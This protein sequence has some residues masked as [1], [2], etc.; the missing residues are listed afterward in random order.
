M[1]LTWISLLRAS[2]ESATVCN[3]GLI[4][5]DHQA[6]WGVVR[7]EPLNRQRSS[8]LAGMAAGTSAALIREGKPG[9]PLNYRS[10]HASILIP[11]VFKALETPRLPKPTT[12]L[13]SL[14]PLLASFL[15]PHTLAGVSDAYYGHLRVCFS[16]SHNLNCHAS[17]PG[18][19]RG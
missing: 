2:V 3:A 14:L 15:P 9:W 10:C 5:C 18:T 17:S 19:V 7:A 1:S 12:T 11:A 13:P 6:K 16:H 8:G 4:H